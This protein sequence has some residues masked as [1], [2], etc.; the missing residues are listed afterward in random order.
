MPTSIVP[1]ELTLQTTST[2]TVNMTAGSIDFVAVVD[3][4]LVVWA[5][6]TGAATQDRDFRLVLD[7]E[8][9]PAGSWQHRATFL[10][11]Q[12]LVAYHLLED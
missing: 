8:D 9:W 3:G 4:Q 11:Q 6:K 2:Q 12:Q 1:Q 5:R 10:D 7:G